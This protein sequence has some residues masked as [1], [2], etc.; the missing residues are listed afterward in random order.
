MSVAALIWAI[1]IAAVNLDSASTVWVVPTLA[2]ACV[3][4]AGATSTKYPWLP[5]A[6][7]ALSIGISLVAF[8][9]LGLWTA[10]CPDCE[11]Y[12]G[13]DPP[14]R[15][16]MLVVWV[17]LGG[18]VLSAYAGGLVLCSHAARLISRRAGRN[19]T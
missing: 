12:H 14:T 9:Y 4:M 7:A 10:S 2:V 19:A 15:E 3:V 11:M 6:L 17:L 13:H 1:G 8:A 18:I 5:A 16:F